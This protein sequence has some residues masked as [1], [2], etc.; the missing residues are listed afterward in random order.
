MSSYCTT[1]ILL[2]ESL[3]LIYDLKITKVNYDIDLWLLAIVGRTVNERY[4]DVICKFT[5]FTP[6]WSCKTIARFCRYALLVCF[7]CLHV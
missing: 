3:S 7:D 5:A 6:T 2:V 1:V 4:M